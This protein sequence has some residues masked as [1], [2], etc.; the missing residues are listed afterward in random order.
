MKVYCSFEV[1]ERTPVQFL[2]VHPLRWQPEWGQPAIMFREVDDE[3]QA[4]FDAAPSMVFVLTAWQ[5]LAEE[6]MSFRLALTNLGDNIGV[7]LLTMTQEALA[8]AMGEAESAPTIAARVM[9]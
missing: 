4:L 3:Q 7:D 5:V 1:D 6:S 9:A 2:A 8:L